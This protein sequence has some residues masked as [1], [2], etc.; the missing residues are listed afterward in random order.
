MCLFT[1]RT[2]LKKKRKRVWSPDGWLDSPPAYTPAFSTTS[3]LQDPNLPVQPPSYRYAN[4]Q[5][6]HL[7]NDETLEAPRPSRRTQGSQRRDSVPY[8]L[9]QAQSE[10]WMS[11]SRGNA[12]YGG[13]NRSRFLSSSQLTPALAGRLQTAAQSVTNL[14]EAGSSNPVFYDRISSRLND[15][16]DEIDNEVFNGEEY[17][18]GM[19]LQP[20]FAK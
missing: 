16:I 8:P 10:P 12:V 3:L 17:A 13:N 5:P 19:G 9:R 7:D 11:S 18:L 2:T 20:S 14:E 4:T 6:T 1:S 15:I